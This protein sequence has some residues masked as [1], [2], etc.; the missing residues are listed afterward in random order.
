VQTAFKFNI[1]AN[2]GIIIDNKCIMQRQ[3]TNYAPLKEH[4]TAQLEHAS[5]MHQ[6]TEL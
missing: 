4:S 5:G 1:K 6:K 3:A 2:E